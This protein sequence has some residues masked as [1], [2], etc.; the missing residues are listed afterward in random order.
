[1]QLVEHSKSSPSIQA[2]AQRRDASRLDR[3][4]VE[5]LLA[6]VGNPPVRIMLWT[7]ESIAT[8]PDAPLAA[9][10][11]AD[12]AALLRLIVDPEMQFGELYMDGRIDCVEGDLVRGLEAVF[13]SAAA[14]GGGPALQS[15][16]ARLVGRSRRNSLR[17]SRRNIHEHYDLSNDFYRLWLD[18]TM[19]YTC[20][21]FPTPGASLHQAQVAKMDHVA[22][23][24][25]VRAGDE[26]IEAGCGWGGFAL[27]LASNYGAK[28]RAF[29]ISS[30]QIAYARERAAK[31][32]LGHRVEFIEDDYR[33]IPGHAAGRCDIFVSVGM[34][35][36]VGKENYGQF[37][38]LIARCLKPDGLGLVHSIGRDA[39]QPVN[40][41]IARHIFPGG[42]VPSLAEMTQ[43]FEPAGL[44]VLDVENLRPHYARTLA[45]WLEGFEG[46]V[47]RVASMFDGRFVRMWRL[48]L[49]SSQAAFLA[50]EM[51]LFQ[52]LFS[53]SRNSEI[54][55]TRA[56][57]YRPTHG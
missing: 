32:G 12:R 2:P 4:M 52:I 21:Y 1:M 22:R 54:P 5:G 11:V 10:R 33:N 23:K 7:G 27:H 53:P 41:W 51:Q 9:F 55:W 15:R 48:Y 37:G 57:I 46:A 16:V 42:F 26:I 20:A 45:H 44:S 14:A 3:R 24:L 40:R 38:R 50:G 56:D 35:E 43:V 8:S 28:V 25:R 18:S 29:N 13:R 6:A 30:E 19:S 39:P 36:H 17:G 31:E 49:A 47:D 34:L